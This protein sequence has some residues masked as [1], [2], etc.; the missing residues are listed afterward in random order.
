[1]IE[2]PLIFLGG[3][4]G[5]A[6]CVGMCGGFAVS[7]GLGSRG[8]AA[9]L[10]RQLVYTAG[11]I[12][13]YSFFGVVAGYAGFWIAGRANLW[14]NAQ[15]TLCLIAGVLLV[16]HGLLAL[17]IVP[18]R[19]WPRVPGGG[20]VCLAGTFVGPFLASPR[21]SN[22][23]L[24]GVLTGFLPC[25]LVY[26]YLALASSSANI[27]EGLLTMCLFG[28]GTAP[29]MI[30]AGAG[31][32]LLSHAARRN[33]MRISAICVA[34]TGLISIVRAILFVQLTPAPLVVR[35]LFCGTPG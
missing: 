28:A 10:G 1:M 13:T 21:V 19:F 22:V 11:R 33:L 26:A 6:H 2:L 15:A 9:N 29:L 34:L 7:I 27:G 12:F 23:L 16:A 32:S 35:C 8:L 31:G 14:I 18:R 3:L 17:G 4:L 24:A 5:S 25:G 30:L 20:S